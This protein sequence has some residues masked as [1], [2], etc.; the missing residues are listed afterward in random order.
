[1]KRLVA[2]LP[3]TLVGLVPVTTLPAAG[4]TGVVTLAYSVAVNHNQPHVDQPSVI[5]V[6]ALPVPASGSV[7]M[8]AKHGTIALSCASATDGLGTPTRA[9]V[10]PKKGGWTIQATL[11][12]LWGSKGS[13]ARGSGSTAVSVL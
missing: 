11:V 4:A 10:F 1:M 8:V 13:K 5:T 6:A 7:T 9:L 2:S 3:G 12:G